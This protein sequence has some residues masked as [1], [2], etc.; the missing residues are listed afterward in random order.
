MDVHPAVMEALVRRCEDGEIGSFLAHGDSSGW[1]RHPVRL[2]G[3]QE[4]VDSATG[5]RSVD[6][7]SATA[8]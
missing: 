4:A 8:Y 2:R 3:R 1:C 5:A 6:F 7:S